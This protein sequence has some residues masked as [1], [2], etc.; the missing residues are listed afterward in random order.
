MLDHQETNRLFV[1][2]ERT[3]GSWLRAE[4]PMPQANKLSW[5]GQS[6]YSSTNNDGGRDWWRRR[7]VR[8]GRAGRLPGLISNF[9]RVVFQDE[10]Q[11]TSPAMKTCG[12]EGCRDSHASGALG[13][14]SDSE[15]LFVYKYFGWVQK[16]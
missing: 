12:D 5:S 16:C 2:V 9:P 14:E 7:V 3:F 1:A 10:S 8:S 11:G 6:C 15:G 4:A 13:G